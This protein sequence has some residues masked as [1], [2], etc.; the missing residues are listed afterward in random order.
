[1]VLIKKINENRLPSAFEDMFRTDWFGGRSSVNNIGISIPAVNIK[2]TDDQ[3]DVEVAAPGKSK[4]DFNI[5][6]DNDTM[7][8]SASAKEKSE[9]VEK[10][11]KYTR[12]EFHF[13]T[14]ERAFSL[15]ETVKSET[16]SAAYEDG[17]LKITIPKREEAKVQPKR[18]IE[19]G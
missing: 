4:E 2:E 14:F 10:K 19:I 6:L 7:T 17:V 11:V 18:L 15:P 16:I 3:F 13:S 9:S 12:R 1:M 8:I 5:E